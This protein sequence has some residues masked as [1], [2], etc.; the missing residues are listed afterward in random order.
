MVEVVPF[1]FL[2]MLY[3]FLLSVEEDSFIE[4]IEDEIDC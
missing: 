1:L 2:D 4:D 3:E